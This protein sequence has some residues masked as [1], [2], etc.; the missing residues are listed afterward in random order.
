[1][2]EESC[3]SG[4]KR[5]GVTCVPHPPLTLK[6][7]AIVHSP[8]KE[9]FGIPRQPGLIA[10][11]PAQIELLPPFNRPEAVR[12]LE[13]FSH[14]WLIFQFHGCPPFDGSLTVRPPRLGGNKRMGVFATR[15][16]HRPNPLG[17]SVVALEGIDCT[18][19]ITLQ[20]RGADLLDQT[21]VFDLKPY[22]PYVDAVTDAIGGFARQRPLRTL[23]VTMSVALRS[24][25]LLLG[26]SR[27]GLLSLIEEVIGYDPRPPFQQEDRTR[28][29]GVRLYD[30]DVRFT[31][32]GTTAEVVELVLS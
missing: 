14:L 15:G 16:T 12:G 27:P 1:M 2:N 28:I 23:N 18:H 25:A 20:I 13:D 6:P 9:K 29:Y 30:L 7:V 10:D 32:Q 17:L 31:V 21:P 24:E 5:A 19:G 4:D 11:V 3:R 22:L 8:F 26:A